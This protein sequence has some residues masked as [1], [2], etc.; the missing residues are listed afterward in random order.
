[1]VPAW[2]WRGF[3]HGETA[4]S[5]NGSNLGG[6]LGL[7]DSAVDDRLATDSRMLH[8]QMPDQQIQ[9]RLLLAVFPGQHAIPSKAELHNKP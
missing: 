7:T 6:F 1:M 5:T 9:G 8:N 3:T 2:S 4:F